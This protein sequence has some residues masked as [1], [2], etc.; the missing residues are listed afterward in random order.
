MTHDFLG[1]DP[2][3]CPQAYREANP[4]L[5]MH[6]NM[7]P[8]WLAHGDQDMVVPIAQSRKFAEQLATL[9]VEHHF[10]VEPG[11]GHTMLQ[12][13]TEPFILLQEEHVIAF[14]KRCLSKSSNA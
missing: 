7:L 13:E 8:I 10:H 2:K 1:G 3:H 14:L 9:G 5:H 4:L 11:A 6:R 12:N